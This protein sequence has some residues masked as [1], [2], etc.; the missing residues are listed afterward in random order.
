MVMVDDVAA[1]SWMM[2]AML[3]QGLTRPSPLLAPNLHLPTAV[4]GW[5]AQFRVEQ[6]VDWARAIL[7]LLV[8]RFAQITAR[9]DQPARTALAHAVCSPHRSIGLIPPIGVVLEPSFA[10]ASASP[11]RN[12]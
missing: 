2:S 5:L 8:Q 7:D 4:V 9:C 3:W 12:L 6:Q 1:P 10:F 11:G